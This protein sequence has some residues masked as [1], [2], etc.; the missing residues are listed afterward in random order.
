MRMIA[1]IYVIVIVITIALVTLLP[2]TILKLIGCFFIGYH[3]TDVA[4]W[5]IRKYNLRNE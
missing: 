5:L 4:E 3:I 2:D 1:F